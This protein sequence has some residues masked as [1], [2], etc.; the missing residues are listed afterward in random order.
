MSRYYDKNKLKEQI[1]TEQIFD[2]VD[3]WGGEPEYSDN[4][5]I[6]QTICHNLPGDG[7]RKLYYYENTKL[8]KCF[9]GCPESSFDIFELAIKVAKRQ[10]NQDWDLYEAMDYVANY[11]GIEGEEDTRT[12]KQKELRDWEVFARHNKLH[13]SPP[14][15]YEPVQLREYNPIILTRFLYPRIADWE[16]E[17]ILPEV[18]RRNMIGYYPGKEQITIPHF[19]MNGRLVGIR[20]RALSTEEADRFGKYR[21]L[22]VGKQMYNHPLSMNLYNLNNSKGNIE[23]VKMALIFESEKSCLQYQSFYGRENDISVAVCGSSLSRYQ[24][25]L[26]RKLGV[27][28]LILGF[29][30]Q[31]QEIGD[32]EFIKLKNKLVHLY[33]KYNNLIKITAIFD[34]NQITPYKAS[35]TDQGKEIFEQ[36]LA[37]RIIPQG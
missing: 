23:Q 1:D 14:Q 32:E 6:A 9:T 21:P 13:S 11:F 19:D 24:V 30:R 5:L 20:G 12:E 28:E 31:F 16:R 29:D 33:N 27:R 25:E 10:N 22:V 4:G 37:E 36:L 17:G 18:S 8:F 2:L 15:S 7:S 35:P 3:L 34:K 26:L